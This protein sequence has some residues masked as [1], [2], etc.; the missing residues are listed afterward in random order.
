MSEPNPYEA[1]QADLGR[2]TRSERWRFTSWLWVSFS[3]TF[4]V[5]VNASVGFVL[6]MLAGF[7]NPF[8]IAA[9]LLGMVT[10]GTTYVMIERWASRAG[11]PLLAEMLVRGAQIRI[12]FLFVPLAE[13]G[14]AMVAI[15]F[16]QHS[17]PDDV[18]LADAPHRPIA[19]FLLTLL[20]GAQLAFMAFMLGALT[21]PYKNM[22]RR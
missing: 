10:V 6:A 21:T 5:C 9:I 22:D 16:L 13:I 4:I 17:M 2:R 3:W 11:Y 1:P 14:A 7:R 19:A 20:V 8:A 18:R 12:L 15:S